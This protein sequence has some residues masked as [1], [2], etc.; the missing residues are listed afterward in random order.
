MN[1]FFSY[2]NDF[3]SS[4][5][6]FFSSLGVDDCGTEEEEEMRE[7]EM[8][9]G[10]EEGRFDDEMLRD[11]TGIDEDKL[12]VSKMLLKE[13]T[14]L[15]DFVT[16]RREGLFDFDCGFLVTG[17]TILEPFDTVLTTFDTVLTTFDTR[18]ECSR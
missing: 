17:T 11:G 16:G 1:D 7:D 4:S 12:E 8:S 15:H 9:D 10:M 2:S 14:E 3:F 18:V 13:E 6:D 5:N